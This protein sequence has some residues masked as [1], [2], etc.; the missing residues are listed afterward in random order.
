V[1]SVSTLFIRLPSACLR[2][3]GGRSFLGC[4]PGC[5]SHFLTCCCSSA[6]GKADAKAESKADAKADSKSASAGDEK[7]AD[8]KSRPKL[9][10]DGMTKLEWE[11]YW[12][13]ESPFALMDYV[14]PYLS[15]LF[16]RS[17]TS[18]LHYAS[19]LLF[20]CRREND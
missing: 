16:L 15:L 3:W 5:S 6:D 19:S 9:V 12:R 2:F 11:E 7:G 13:Y 18:A 20:A 14:S 4:L 8:G 1:A 17:V 10:T